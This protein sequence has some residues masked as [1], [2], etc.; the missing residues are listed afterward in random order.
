MTRMFN[1]VVSG[2]VQTALG[3]AGSAHRPGLALRGHGR[4]APCA[5]SL[6]PEGGRPSRL[7]AARGAEDMGVLREQIVQRLTKVCGLG[8]PRQIRQ[9]SKLSD[10]LRREVTRQ[11]CLV[12]FRF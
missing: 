3:D 4:S 5:P 2:P 11:L 9:L 12:A 10:C 8:N 6:R 7:L 1:E